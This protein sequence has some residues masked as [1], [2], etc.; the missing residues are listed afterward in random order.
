MPKYRRSLQLEKEL[1]LAK[2]KLAKFETVERDVDK[3]KSDVQQEL[4]CASTKVG[5]LKITCC[6]SLEIENRIEQEIFLCRDR[7]CELEV[8][9]SSFD[10]KVT[11]LE[12]TIQSLENKKES[13]HQEL[14]KT[15]KKN[16][17]VEI[18]LET[19]QREREYVKSGEARLGA[20]TNEYAIGIRN[21]EFLE[22]EL[23]LMKLREVIST[24][25][26]Q[27][28]ALFQDKNELSDELKETKKSDK[29]NDRECTSRFGKR[30]TK[31]G[32]RE[33]STPNHH[34][35]L[36]AHDE[37]ST[38]EIRR[39]HEVAA[40][41]ETKYGTCKTEL[42]NQ[43]NLITTIISRE[44]AASR[45]AR[46]AAR[47]LQLQLDESRQEMEKRDLM[48]KRLA[49][50]KRSLEQ[51]ILEFRRNY[52][53]KCDTCDAEL[54]EE[55]S[56]GARP[57]TETRVVSTKLQDCVEKCQQGT[58]FISQEPN[59]QKTG[60][61]W[62]RSHEQKAATLLYKGS[63]STHNDY[64][65]RERENIEILSPGEPLLKGHGERKKEIFRGHL[66]NKRRDKLT[67]VRNRRQFHASTESANESADL[68]WNE[69]HADCESK[70]REC[71]HDQ[72]ALKTLLMAGEDGRAPTVEMENDLSERSAE[73][74]SKCEEYQ[75]NIDGVRSGSDAV[76]IENCSLTHEDQEIKQVQPLV[77]SN[78]DEIA[79][80]IAESEFTNGH[81]SPV[82]DEEKDDSVA[83]VDPAKDVLESVKK[84][85]EELQQ[86]CEVLMEERDNATR[87]LKGRDDEV[88]RLRMRAV[89]TEHERADMKIQL[90]KAQDRSDVLEK[91]FASVKEENE[92]LRA[93]VE[94]LRK[95]IEELE[96]ENSDLK[97][98]LRARADQDHADGKKATVDL[99]SAE[100][101]RAAVEEPVSVP[102][103][104]RHDSKDQ[105]QEHRSVVDNTTA[106]EGAA[107]ESA[108]AA[109]EIVVKRREK[110][111]TAPNYYRHSFAGSLPRPFHSYELPSQRSVDHSSKHERSESVHS[112]TSEESESGGHAAP[113]VPSFMRRKANNPYLKSGFSPVQFNYQPLPESISSRRESW[114]DG[115]RARGGSFSK[116]RDS[117]SDSESSGIGSGVGAS[118][119]KN[120]EWVEREE[121]ANTLNPAPKELAKHAENAE[122][123]TK[124]LLHSTHEEHESVSSEQP[125]EGTEVIQSNSQSQVD[126]EEQERTEHV[127]D[128]VSM[129]NSRTAEVLDV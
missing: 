10:C 87:S 108:P 65:K 98:K 116:A 105:E 2:K 38:D 124:D 99:E 128:L 14:L 106:S 121:T 95:R 74:D 89:E 103:E 80:P 29:E 119:E 13:L 90:A 115:V 55:N 75:P 111:R 91:E 30:F 21:K 45:A 81:A 25:E 35:I 104:E 94:R 31:G 118:V 33:R 126:G 39:L 117:S 49:E 69:P 113:S 51:N 84:R 44:K 3:R 97:S 12:T 59:R 66:S 96:A 125:P 73:Y 18:A 7:T 101:V 68:E 70:Y 129:W 83:S 28:D 86:L 52:Q 16:D 6:S 88:L 34:F 20:E 37:K 26:S 64:A 24:P 79:S 92:K 19:S 122:N 32:N 36:E 107:K 11:D 93:E 23:E 82:P 56:L 1:Y 58:D 72:N 85:K 15:R 17:D 120:P 63:K 47:E 41:L 43:Q 54:D 62:Y 40:D 102:S 61:S 4:L 27:T 57:R 22:A 114:L 9:L 67:E 78:G 112:D 53:Q 127:S 76:E 5:R 48:M 46:A 109:D 60:S 50:D 42:E 123:S 8:Q 77:V 110:K 71:C 100:L